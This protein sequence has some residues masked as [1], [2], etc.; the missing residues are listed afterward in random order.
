MVT[1][2]GER[3]GS[4]RRSEPG[5]EVRLKRLLVVVGKPE[6]TARVLDY[7]VSHAASGAAIDAVL[8]CVEPESQRSQILPYAASD[9]KLDCGRS[10]RDGGRGV[11]RSAAD[12]LDRVGI[13]H[14][15]LVEIGNVGAAIVRCAKKEQCD[16]V[17]LANP[18]SDISTETL[19]QK[20]E[21]AVRSILRQAAHQ[22]VPLQVAI[23]N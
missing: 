6:Q 15:E 21:L 5:S 23:V 3:T 1:V 19:G 14:R 8:L 9:D 7:V 2:T 13:V 18:D 10:A 20:A 17:V 12:R 22:V 4:T 11:L 16:L